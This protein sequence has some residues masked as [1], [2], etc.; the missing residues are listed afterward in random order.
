[1][2]SDFC[3]IIYSSIS[4]GI[5]EDYESI[6]SQRKLHTNNSKYSLRWDLINSNILERLT[7]NNIEVK[8]V[9]AGCWSFLL[10]LN[11]ENG[12]LYSLMNSKRYNTICS[13]PQKNAPLYIRALKEL[14]RN[15]GFAN[16]PLFDFLYD[17]SEFIERLQSMCSLFSS[18]VNFSEIHYKILTFTTYESNVVDM[19]LKTLDA[20]LNELY[21][22]KLFDY[23][24]P[25]FDNSIMQTS[26]DE[27]HSP[28]LKI[29]KK[30]EKRKGE[31]EKI[32][33]KSQEY[34]L[35]KQA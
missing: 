32:S 3:Q 20:N 15:L 11:K 7:N 4:Q 16:N 22:E 5:K 13:K 14:N 24:I 19:E 17:G 1:M 6:T 8:I 34:H 2:K 35:N 27:N 9:K 31:K 18:S 28:V 25:E 30:A 23:I 10:I 26:N 29:T 21:S 33:L 12:T